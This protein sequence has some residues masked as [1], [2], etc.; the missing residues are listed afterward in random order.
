VAKNIS[1]SEDP[2]F[3]FKSN[4]ISLHEDYCST[5]NKLVALLSLWR[6]RGKN[7]GRTEIVGTVRPYPELRTV[8]KFHGNNS[9]QNKGMPLRQPV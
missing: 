3:I 5:R 6:L 8:V 7:N 9:V 1:N 2:N 4:V